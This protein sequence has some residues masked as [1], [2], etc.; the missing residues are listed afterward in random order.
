MLRLCLVGTVAILAAVTLLSGPMPHGRIPESNPASTWTEAAWANIVRSEYEFRPRPDGAWSAPNRAQGLRLTANGSVA[1]VTPRTEGAAPWVLSLGLRS[2]GRTGAM[3]PL[4]AGTLRAEGNRLQLRREGLGLTEWYVNL[5]TGIEQ[6]FTLDRRPEA[7]EPGS[8]LVLDIFYEGGLEA[9]QEEAGGAVLF[10]KPGAGNVLRYADL[11]VADA[12]GNPV[13]AALDLAP[14]S[15]RITIQDEGHP[16]PLVVDPTIVV[17]AW[18]GRGDQFEELFG[19]SV[20]GAGDVNNDGYDDLIVGAPRF[21]GDFF[22]EGRAFVFLGS[23]TGPST[24]PSWTASGDQTGCRFGTAVASAGDVNHDGYADVIIGARNYD[25]VQVDE[26]RAF[27]YLGL[28]GGLATLPIWTA[29]PDQNLAGFGAAVASAGD[30]NGDGFDDVI[31]GAPLFDSPF[32]TDEGAAFVYLGSASGPALSPAWVQG[33]GLFNSAFGTSVASAGDVNHDGYDEVIVGAPL[34]DN[35][36]FS[37]Q[38]RVFV[39]PGSASGL[40]PNPSWTADGAKTLARFGAWVGPAGDVNYD[41]FADVIIGAPFYDSG[42]AF[43][44]LG[45]AAGLG[46]T[47]NW[48]N[49]LN[50]SPAE[51]G[52]SVAGVGDLDGD[53]F[54]DVV[55]GAPAVDDHTTTSVGLVKAFNGGLMGVGNT[56]AFTVQETQAGARLGAAVA[57]AGDVN[58]D[59]LGDFIAGATGL[60]NPGQSVSLAGAAHLYL[61]FRSTPCVPAP[62]TCN[63]RD[64]DCDGMVDDG[65]GT[66]TCGTGACSRTVQNCAD[67]FPQT[68]TPGTPGTETCNGIDDDCDGA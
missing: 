8:P 28:A 47:P 38:G 12:D 18:T 56:A 11:A 14:G 49:K 53:G 63:R 35:A 27:V 32:N 60:D 59:G 57:G 20:A 34:Y 17:P 33:S 51:Y 1:D 66:I 37:D 67:G 46:L 15:L 3:T 40:S 4:V 58:G 52:A 21:D 61:G 29:E 65:L 54:D 6:G 68:C 55:V 7:V 41:G 44:Y 22:D 23:A 16:Y 10:S 31:V 9:R 30:V 24:A 42:R 45:S 2:V 39:Y 43:V 25:F 48:N 5:R 62:E 36:G 19:A 64:D 13:V 26:G 50:L